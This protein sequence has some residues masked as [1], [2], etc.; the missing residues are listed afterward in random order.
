MKTLLLFLVSSLVLLVGAADLRAEDQYTC[1]MHPHYISTD[2]DGTCP[3]CGMD[4][5]PLKKDAMAAGGGISVESA[6]LQTMGVRTATVATARFGEQV[7]AFGNVESNTRLEAVSV[8]R[9]EGWIEDLTVRAEG[10]MVRPGALLYRIYSPTLIAAQKDLIAALKIGNEA[11]IAAVRQRLRSLGMQPGTIARVAESRTVAERVPVYAEAGGT[12]LRLE[13]RDGTYVRP[14]TPILRLQSYAEV[15]VIASVAEQDIEFIDTGMPASLRFPSAARAPREGRVDFIYPTID[16]RTRTARVRI[17]VD[18]SAGHLRPGAYADVTFERGGDERLSVPKEAV[19]RDSR[20]AHVI[21]AL[22]EGRFTSRAVEIGAS[23]SERTEIVS[24][25]VAGD[26][27]VASGQFLLDSEINLREGMAKFGRPPLSL[28]TPL[29]ELPLDGSNLALLDHFVDAALY[30]HEALTDRYQVDATFLEPTLKIG[31]ILRVEYANS[32]LVPIIDSSVRAL[33]GAQKAR[34][35]PLLAQQLSA[36]VTAL[37]PW[38]LRGAPAHY[39]NV[40]LILYRDKNGKLWLQQGGPARNPY[41]TESFSRVEWPDPMAG[42][43]VAQ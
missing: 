10:D 36:L 17:E 1:P 23:S 4:L 38:L 32:Q 22:G 6:M 2:P 21:L 29:S 8:S 39:R 27:V 13:A 5:V 19:L 37:E 15:W 30:L 28:Q 25:L 14:G 26:R 3:I 24:G 7:R 41:G 16:A 9:L 43:P 35:G 12:V 11:R 31:A 33:Q 42:T 20:G 18:N 40:G 34:S